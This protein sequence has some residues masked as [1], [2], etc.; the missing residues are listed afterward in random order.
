MAIAAQLTQAEVV[1]LRLYTGPI[2]VAWNTALRMYD[3]NPELLFDWQT[4]ISILYSA[5]FKLSF[6]SKPGKVYRGVNESKLKLPEAFYRH[7]G[8]NFAGGVELAFMSTSYDKNV[9]VEYGMR[10]T[11]KEST[12]FEIEFDGGNRG[13]KVKWVSQFPYEEELL[14]PPC[15]YLTCKSVTSVENIRHVVVTASVSNARPNLKNIRTVK[16]NDKDNDCL[17][18]ALDTLHL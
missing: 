3:S 9:A 5:V 8:H 16:D 18:K 2:Y 12:I 17:D 4:S 10:G 15:T 6:L 11:T 1:A 13:A 14:Y 7:D